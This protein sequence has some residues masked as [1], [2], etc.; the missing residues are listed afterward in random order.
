MNKSVKATAP[1]PWPGPRAGRPADGG[2]AAPLLPAARA[3][4]A[5]AGGLGRAAMVAMPC[6]PP[7]GCRGD[8]L[9]SIPPAKGR[10][11]IAGQSGVV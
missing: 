8:A 2:Y 5:C 1:L 6:V 4:G 10:P 7:T 3:P 11:T 9:K